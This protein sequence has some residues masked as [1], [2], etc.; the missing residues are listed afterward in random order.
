MVQYSGNFSVL[1]DLDPVLTDIFYNE[2]AREIGDGG[3]MQLFAV[4]RSTKAKETDLRIGG[5]R[6]PVVFNGK[7]QY[8]D[9]ERDYTVEYSHTE[10]AKGFMVERKLIDDNQYETI[11]ERPQELAIATARKRRKD[12]ASVFNNAFSTSF[13]GFDGK[14]LCE[15]DHPRSRTDS[16]AVDN[17]HTLALSSANLETVVVAMQ[18]F[19]DDL[20]EE[21]TIIPDRLVVPRTLRKTAI[22]ILASDKVPENA[23]NTANVQNAA[24]AFQGGWRMIVDPYLTDPNAWF[25]VDSTMARR[26]L[27]WYD[28]ILPEFANEG[29]FDTL[30]S[31]FRMYMRYSY[32][33]SNFRWIAGSNPS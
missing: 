15:D 5:F 24:Y 29:D 1:T 32:G 8:D 21:I 3:V 12:A 2:Y 25:V 16:T 28:R 11:F 23:N 18:G 10:F 19:K 20:G 4:R 7:V 6:D 33:W 26:Y 31:K 22:E 27:K 17:E 14:P 30:V 13:L 9:A